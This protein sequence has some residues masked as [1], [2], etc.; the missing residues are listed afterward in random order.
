MIKT[1]EDFNR[2]WNGIFKLE[3]S[4]KFQ[5]DNRESQFIIDIRHQPT[6]GEYQLVVDSSAADIMM[7]IDNYLD[8]VFTS[9]RNKK[10]EQILK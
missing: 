8:H 1:I 10:I 6:S 7:I 3:F 5:S 4:S 2:Q 9:I